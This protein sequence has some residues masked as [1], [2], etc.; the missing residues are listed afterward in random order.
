[1]LAWREERMTRTNFTLHNRHSLFQE[2]P[3]YSSGKK[4]HATKKLQKLQFL[5]KL[6]SRKRCPSML[7]SITS[8]KYEQKLLPFSRPYANHAFSRRGSCNQK[9][10][11]YR[12]L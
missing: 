5:Q 8:I 6:V 3:V 11:F 10:I 4:A 7:P 12:N 1:M 9:M 2:H